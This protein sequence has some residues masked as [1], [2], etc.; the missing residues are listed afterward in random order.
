MK[1]GYRRLLA[2]ATALTLFA[3]CVCSSVFVSAERYQK[4]EN[5]AMH[6]ATIT[7]KKT[8]NTG[9]AAGT[10]FTQTLQNYNDYNSDSNGKGTTETNAG[11]WILVD[12]YF[13]L[14]SDTLINGALCN[15]TT[16]HNYVVVDWDTQDERF[17]VVEAYPA[18]ARQVFQ[19][20][21][22]GFVLIQYNTI[23]S[24]DF[25][26]NLQPGTEVQVNL[27]DLMTLIN[28]RQ[29][30]YN[31]TTYEQMILRSKTSK[32]P[33]QL[34]G[35]T[36]ST[37]DTYVDTTTGAVTGLTGS[38]L[39]LHPEVYNTAM[40][41]D[42]IGL[43]DSS[44]NMDLIP[45]SG[46]GFYVPLVPTGDPNVY[47]VKAGYT[48]PAYDSTTMVKPASIPEG[49]YLLCMTHFMSSYIKY[50]A[51]A[52]NNVT[53]RYLYQNIAKYFAA[54]KKFRIIN[55]IPRNESTTDVTVTLGGVKYDVNPL[56]Y[57]DSLTAADVEKADAFTAVVANGA[58]G[59]TP[60]FSADTA[61]VSVVNDVIVSVGNAES[62]TYIPANGYVLS[63]TGN[64]K[65]AL[66]NAKVGD[67]VK[68]EKVDAPTF[69]DD[70]VLF[71]S[72][73]IELAGTNIARP[74]DG[75]VIYNGNAGA[76][77]GTDT[78]GYEVAV[79]ADGSIISAGGNN[80]PIPTDGFVLSAGSE[81]AATL[82]AMNFAGVRAALDGFWPVLT[83]F[84]SPDTLAADGLL[85]AAEY[86]QLLAAAGA[87]MKDLSYEEIEAA[88]VVAKDSAAT[89]TALRT[90]G[91]DAAKKAA[92]FEAVGRCVDDLEQAISAIEPLFYPIVGVENRAI[93]VVPAEKDEAAVRA[94]L[95]TIRNANLDTVYVAAFRNGYT[96]F[97]AES[98]GLRMMEALEG[99][100]ALG[101][102]VRIGHELGLEVRAWVDTLRAATAD[103]EQGLKDAAAYL[104]AEHTDWLLTSRNGDQGV[105]EDGR[106][107]YY[108]DPANP[109]V[110]A[111]L[112]R[113]YARLVAEYKV[114][115]VVLDSLTFPADAPAGEDGHPND[116]G[117]TVSM[118]D[119]Y[120]AKYDTLT[121]FID[122]DH[123][124]WGQW[125][126]FK[127]ACFND[128][129]R[130][131]TTQLH[132][133]DA[134]LMVSAMVSP[135]F[136][137]MV[138]ARQ[139]NAMLWAEKG[140]IDEFIIRGSYADTA[141]LEQA[142][143]AVR[144]TV[145]DAASVTFGLTV[146]GLS[147]QALTA[148]VEA[149]QALNSTGTALYTYADWATGGYAQALTGSVYRKAVQARPDDLEKSLPAVLLDMEKKL[150]D[151][152][153][154]YDTAN[155]AA[156]AALS[157]QVKALRETAYTPAAA[158]ALKQAVTQLGEAVDAAVIAAAAKTALQSK[159]QALND[160]LSLAQARN[161]AQKKTVLTSLGVSLNLGEDEAP[162]ARQSYDF[163]VT[164]TVT[165]DGESYTVRLAPSQYA[166]TVEDGTASVEN[167]ILSTGRNANFRLSVRVTDG[168][169]LPVDASV[170]AAQL[171][172]TA[173]A[174]DEEDS[175]VN[176]PGQDIPFGDG[177]KDEEQ[178]SASPETGE[179]SLWCVFAMLIACM[180][181]A[182][183]MLTR[184]NRLMQK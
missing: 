66:Q 144:E 19:I 171:S 44:A 53:A 42:Y 159:L 112:S 133:L 1:L 67:V 142:V 64:K 65:A 100:D 80:T 43:Y 127:T 3:T 101:A 163:I 34:E 36:I 123:E 124:Q 85:R 81:V 22:Y 166:V 150:T 162:L 118:T 72:Q 176:E 132:S 91:D 32:V 172:Y 27:D 110:V 12:R 88:I 155:A 177:N 83:F 21:R 125:L 146:A 181:A 8:D 89:L 109:E 82:Q 156:Y 178:P 29:N 107:A 90:P 7:F 78:A 137:A 63:A 13:G 61:Q 55:T 17:E 164:G 70:Q 160:W 37:L 49:E 59:W 129:V 57:S 116:F 2:I 76:T 39:V 16:V 41:T 97:P 103:S 169:V 161:E 106:T 147:P 11:Y 135:D 73:T 168:Y 60:L 117:Y 111:L 62:G 131:L 174:A 154:K 126:D 130:Q 175:D 180:A 183:A 96:A 102:Y 58:N 108:L 120:A 52:S 170:A 20:P 145:K 87:E 47:Q 40:Y 179:K 98:E 74:A 136:E 24:A 122:K 15:P 79:A 153:S 75:F 165:V 54:G 68:F 30:D 56:A 138:E 9:M 114:D 113:L 119:A 99:F 173:P 46:R 23:K 134:D 104:A 86:E 141:A 184:K 92:Y 149:L 5:N 128:F 94:V 31:F 77:T 167:G 69:T 10:D 26:K 51:Y 28:S 18:G 71:T 121:Y 105:A 33:Q 158:A 139:Q 84:R 157:Q 148:Q 4:T 25:F 48:A 151:V 152:Y 35:I 143:A 45:Q 140:Y 93:W 38:P 182:M 95:E 50:G 14:S 6:T 115:G